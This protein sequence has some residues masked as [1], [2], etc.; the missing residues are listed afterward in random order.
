MQS[1]EKRKEVFERLPEA[2]ALRIMVVPS[3]ISQLIVL[4]YN[5]ADILLCGADGK[6]L[7]GGCHIPDSPGI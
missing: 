1:E 6:S 3:V 4:I 5:M 7:Y 2:S